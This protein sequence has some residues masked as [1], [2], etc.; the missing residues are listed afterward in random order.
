LLVDKV[1]QLILVMEVVLVEQV[2]EEVL[3]QQ[4]KV[5]RQVA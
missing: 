4:G 5:I 2:L 1:H 3:Q